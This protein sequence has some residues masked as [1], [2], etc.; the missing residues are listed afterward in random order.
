MP[1]GNDLNA[2]RALFEAW[3]EAVK[4]RTARLI[5][6]NENKRKRKP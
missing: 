1:T 3:R 2:T 4:T 5:L 6:P